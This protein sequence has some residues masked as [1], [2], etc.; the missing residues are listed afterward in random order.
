LLVFA[1]AG[2]V[3]VYYFR[4]A[5]QA[6]PAPIVAVAENPKPAKD[7]RPHRRRGARRLPHKAI[8][9]DTVP[10]EAPRGEL[11]SRD[12]VAPRGAAAPEERPTLPGGSSVSEAPP[13]DVFGSSSPSP[14][15]PQAPAGRLQAANDPPPVKL[16]PSDLR[17]VWQGEDLSKAEPMRLDMSNDNGHDLT[18]A[19]IDE[20]FRTKEDAVLGCIS[21]ARPTEDTDV[22]GHVT[23]RFRILRTGAIKGV[24]VEAP[25]ILHKG[26]LTGCI[27]SAL[28]S[29][30]FPASNMA[31]VISFPF[32]L[33]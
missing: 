5:V 19:E 15:L 21:R 23:V 1:A 25:V 3:G 28:A 14:S 17:I 9:G 7:R 30:R 33:M 6:P 20:R 2:L 22:P 16:R 26:G 18:D 13:D 27:K 11:P 29:L 24:Q 12:E 31:Q 10:A 8:A 4:R 32:S